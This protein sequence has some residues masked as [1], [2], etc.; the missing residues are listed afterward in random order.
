MAYR[1]KNDIV[2]ILNAGS[3]HMKTIKSNNSI[4]P[5]SAH[6][7]DTIKNKNINII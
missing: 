3:K 7:I 5:I 6:N 4:N 2:S 1:T